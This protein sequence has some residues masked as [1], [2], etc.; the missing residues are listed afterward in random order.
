MGLVADNER[1]NPLSAAISF[2]CIDYGLFDPAEHKQH[3][4]VRHDIIFV[5]EQR[6]EIEID[7]IRVRLQRRWR[8][9]KV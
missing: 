7:H 1:M 9:P 3:L 4:R 8:V 2:P 5:R 6:L